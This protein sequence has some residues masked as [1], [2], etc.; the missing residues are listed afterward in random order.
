MFHKPDFFSE[1]ISIEEFN[2]IRKCL[3]F[4]KFPH[5]VISSRFGSLNQIIT[6]DYVRYYI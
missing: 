3:L 5:N 1:S 2:T 6:V 4:I